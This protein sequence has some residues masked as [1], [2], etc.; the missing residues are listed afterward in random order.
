MQLICRTRQRR[1][2][3]ESMDVGEGRCGDIGRRSRCS[4]R[5]C[6]SVVSHDG[7]CL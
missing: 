2:A 7:Y 5:W 4:R 6:N 3:A 1:N